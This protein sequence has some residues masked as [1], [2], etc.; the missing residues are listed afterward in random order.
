MECARSRAYMPQSASSMSRI[1]YIRIGGYVVWVRGTPL[2][3]SSD[4]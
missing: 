4:Y 3:N 2:S 1:L